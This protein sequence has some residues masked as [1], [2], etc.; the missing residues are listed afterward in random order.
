MS[1]EK[2]PIPKVLIVVLVIVGIIA[3]SFVGLI[4]CGI[5][6]AIAI[7]AFLKHSKHPQTT[8]IQIKPPVEHS[9]LYSSYI[10]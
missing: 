2:N 8:Y 7:P 6:S 3:L 10:S 1:K 4:I 5:I 9:K